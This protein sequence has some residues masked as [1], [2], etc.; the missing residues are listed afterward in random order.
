MLHV[1]ISVIVISY[2]LHIFCRITLFGSTAIANNVLHFNVTHTIKEVSSL[3]V[4]KYIHNQEFT[5]S[6]FY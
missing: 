6:S 3:L 5:L 2:V 1:E 4:P